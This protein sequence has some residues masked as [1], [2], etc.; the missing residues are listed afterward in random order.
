MPADDDSS[1]GNPALDEASQSAM[2]ALVNESIANLT[3]NLTDVIQSR[4]GDFATNFSAQNSC[5]VTNAVKRVRFD[6]YICKRKDDRQQL[7]HAHDV[8]EKFDD[9]TDALKAGAHERVKRSLEEG[10]RLLSKCIKAIKF[11]DNSEFG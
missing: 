6:R 8:L 10:T 4:L 9:A 11:A 3:D 2:K 5:T 7:D 1:R